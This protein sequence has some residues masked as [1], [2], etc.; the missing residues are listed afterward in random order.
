MA[1][2]RL[3]DAIA[4]FD[5]SAAGGGSEGFGGLLALLLLVLLLLGGLFEVEALVGLD[6]VSDDVVFV[7]VFVGESST[8]TA[9]PFFAASCALFPPPLLLLLL[10]VVVVVDV[11]GLLVVAE[12]VL[13]GM[14]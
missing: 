3:G 12:F 13:F 8:T 14:R 1:P 4:G 6:A 2:S 5:A 9:S 11:L 7:A 10:V